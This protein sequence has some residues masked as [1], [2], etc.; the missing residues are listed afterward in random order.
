MKKLKLLS[1]V[2]WIHG[3]IHPQLNPWLHFLK[4]RPGVQLSSSQGSLEF[5]KLER[6]RVYAVDAFFVSGA[7]SIDISGSTQNTANLI[8]ENNGTEFFVD[9]NN[10]FVFDSNE[11]RGLISEIESISVIAKDNEGFFYWGGNFSAA[12]LSISSKNNSVSILDVQEAHLQATFHAKNNVSI[13]AHDSITFDEEIAVDGFLAIGVSGTGIVA[14]EANAQVRVHGD[15]IINSGPLLMLADDLTNSWQIDGATNL[16]STGPVSIGIVGKWDSASFSASCSELTVQDFNNIDLAALSI[17]G[18][19]SI[20][21]PESIT[22]TNGSEISIGG[23]LILSGKVISLADDTFD[24]IIVF[25]ATTITASTGDVTIQQNGLVQLGDITATGANITIYEDDSTSLAGIS[26]IGNLVIESSGAITDNADA[27]I[28]ATASG[29]IQG[30]TIL[31][32]NTTNDV[33]SI[34]GS[35]NFVATSGAMLL[36]TAGTVSLASVS[37]S[38]TNVTIHEDTSTTLVNIYATGNLVVQSLGAITDIPSASIIAT[39]SSYFTGTTITLSD[40]TTDVLNIGGSVEFTATS[41]IVSIDAAGTVTL[42]DLSASGTN[43]KIYEDASTTLSHVLAVGDVFVE[44]FGSV[45]D[46]DSARVEATVIRIFANTFISLADGNNDVIR[47]YGRAFLNAVENISIQDA[48]DVQFGSLGFVA[49]D[50]VLFEDGPTVLDGVS[51]E[52]LN[53]SAQDSISQSGLDTGAGTKFIHVAG[54]THFD[55]FASPGSIDLQR[56]P[57]LLWM[58]NS[59]SGQVTANGIQG[60]FL[61]RNTSSS[62]SIGLISGSFDNFSVWHTNNSIKTSGQ[63]FNIS[64][65]LTLIAGVDVS[66]PNQLSNADL[67]QVRNTLASIEDQGTKIIVGGKA[68]IVAGG[69]ILI[70]DVAG[71]SFMSGN[72]LV[73]IVSLGG[74]DISVGGSGDTQIPL[75]GFNTENILNHD[76]GDITIQLD[77]SSTLSNPVLPFPDG[78]TLAIHSNNSEIMLSGNLG[79]LPGTQISILNDL[80]VSA[81]GSISLNNFS[82]ESLSVIGQSTFISSGSSIQIG[83]QGLMQLGDV[84]FIANQGDVIVGGSGATRLGLISA[85]ADNIAIQEDAELTIK[86]A[87]ADGNLVLSSTSS[88]LST[89]AFKIVDMTG[90]SAYRAVVSA[91]TFAHLGTTHIDRLSLAVGQNGRLAGISLFELNGIANATGQEYLQALGK[92]LPGGITPSGQTLSGESVEQLR[93]LASFEASFGKNYGFYIRN[94]K[95][96][97]VESAYNVGDGIHSYIETLA[98]HDITITGNFVQRFTQQSAGGIVLIAGD[99]VDFAPSGRLIIES[100]IDDVTTRRVITQPSL[101]ASAFDGQL[102]PSGFQSTRDVLY[103]S[104]ANADSGTQNVLQR[105]STQFGVLGESGF[106]TLVQYSDG[107]SQLFN[108]RQELYGS[109]INGVSATPGTGVISAHLSQTGDAAVFQRSVPFADTFLSTFQTLPTTAIFRRSEEFFI[110]ANGGRTDN[111]VGRVDLTPVVDE[112]GE[113]YSPGRKIS[114]SLPSEIVVTPASVVPIPKMFIISD[115]NYAQFNTDVESRVIGQV[116][117]QVSIVQVGFD[118]Q[119]N[120][121]QVSDDELPTRNE[122][123]II[124]LEKGLED[125]DASDDEKIK[126][127]T[128]LKKRLMLGEVDLASKDVKAASVATTQDIE[129]WIEEYKNNANK[130]AGAYAIIAVDSVNGIKILKVF[131]IRDFDPDGETKTQE[132]LEKFQEEIDQ[133]NALPEPQQPSE[134]KPEVSTNLKYRLIPQQLRPEQD[135]LV[136]ASPRYSGPVKGTA[137]ATMLSS[138]GGDADD[139]EDAGNAQPLQVV[140]AAGALSMIRSRRS[141]GQRPVSAIP[142]RSEVPPR[143]SRLARRLRLT[144]AEK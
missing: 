104:D 8:N 18:S 29:F 33:L 92:N 113:V 130:P 135:W 89:R 74:K 44:S 72:P 6:R 82:S 103:A 26:V 15:L 73:A 47:S 99:Q 67:S 114:F 27:S 1:L 38:G 12:P 9:E 97:I 90:I 17:S 95:S 127:T 131:S 49:M 128:L 133:P 59:I 60:D 111:A 2:K 143:F 3:W 50:V 140:L 101:T 102:G 10:D 58:E 65:Y 69:Y 48:G 45:T 139:I 62:A 22:D 5:R 138:S 142:N 117:F 53:V 16:F 46:V 32:A 116:T 78:R 112:V 24:K 28:I 81:S 134:V 85:F 108:M 56:S 54:D 118:D 80:S 37:A 63:S 14:D 19:A 137:L 39:G 87:F 105:V 30:S 20:F 94:D 136:E 21:T 70:N 61:L 41:G 115:V 66:N 110:F 75:L 91:A 40:N 55:L 11:V 76:R 79:S 126:S 64:Q 125:D 71:E 100:S 106:Q 88:I 57:G 51:V 42:G 23:E 25:G 84:N 122:I 120:D 93:L 141:A 129:T 124:A 144:Q 35:A 83:S 121:G 36:D 7:L 68:H 34:G 77:G 43:I 4:P 96:I 107:N 119:D 132:L 109:L 86:A 52:T 98:G 31:L 123:Q 13:Y